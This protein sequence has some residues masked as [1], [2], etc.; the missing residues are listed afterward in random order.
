MKKCTKIVLTGI[1]V[2]LFASWI[3]AIAEPPLQ[4][5]GEN[6]CPP[7]P[8]ELEEL[9]A[10]VSRRP[11]KMP[12]SVL[13]QNICS[14]YLHKDL[15]RKETIEAMQYIHY[16]LGVFIGV[17]Y[18]AVANSNKKVGAWY[19]IPAGAAVWQLTHGS[20]VPALGL[21]GKVKDMPKSWWVWEFGSH[22]VFGV[23]LEMS[24]RLFCKLFK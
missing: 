9:G 2:G 4:K 10:D 12:P 1:G 16:G 22:I 15:S 18:T 5:W 11:E 17:V 23:A 3:K 21:Q 20:I 24:R 8:D 7:T 13:A 14:H 6:Q 19:G